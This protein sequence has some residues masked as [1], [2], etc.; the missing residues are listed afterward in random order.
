MKLKITFLLSFRVSLTPSIRTKLDFFFLAFSC[1]IQR[2]IFLSF[3]FHIKIL[4][5]LKPSYFHPFLGEE[6]Y[7]SL[8][9]GTGRNLILLTFFQI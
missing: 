6:S 1:T 9:C 5:C 2:S 8:D 4:D 3:L 7:F